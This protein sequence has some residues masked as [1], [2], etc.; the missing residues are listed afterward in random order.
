MDLQ[1]RIDLATRLG[2]YI[3][4]NKEAWQ[5]AKFQAYRSNPWFVPE[6][7]ELATQQIAEHFLSAGA[8]ATWAAQYNVPNQVANPLRIG[9]VMAGNLPLVGFHD[10]LSVFISGHRAVIKLSSKDTILLKHLAGKLTEWNGAVADCVEFADL[11]K[12]CDAYIATGSSN[13]GRYFEYYFS[14]YPHIIRR[15]R[16][17]VAVLTGKESLGE[18]S[19]LADDMLVYFG[20]GCRNVTKLFVPAGYDFVPLLAALKKHEDLL[21][22]HKYKHNYDYHLTLLIMNQREYMNN[23]LMVLCESEALFPPISQAYYS[24]YQD[25]TA[26]QQTLANHSTD[27]QCITGKGYMPFGSTQQP[28]LTDYADGVDTL[29]FLRNLDKL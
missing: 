25:E 7:I 13:T 15:N 10:F 2:S 11:L 27:I 28:S 3:Q 22:H 18:L 5:E 8:L 4:E 14:K 6:F 1:I 20:L 24:F 26:L 12:N 9:L 19:K 21:E 23:G 16:T 29:Q 17:S